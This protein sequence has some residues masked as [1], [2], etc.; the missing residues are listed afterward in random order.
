MVKKGAVRSAAIA[1]KVNV[2]DAPPAVAVIT[3]LRLVAID[4][5][6]AV[7]VWRVEPAGTVT[8]AGTRTPTLE[9]LRLTANPPAGASPLRFTVQVEVPGAFTL[10]GV[11]LSELGWIV[12]KETAIEPPDGI[13]LRST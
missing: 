6:V 10:D 3:E 13:G 8:E 12:G 4:P 7:K 11:Q 9:L 5:T 2:L 1:D